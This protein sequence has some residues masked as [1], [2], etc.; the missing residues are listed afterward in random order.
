MSVYEKMVASTKK[1]VESG[2]PAEVNLGDSFNKI[3]AFE[4][5]GDSKPDFYLDIKGGKKLSIAEGKHQKPDIV[6][7][8]DKDTMTSIRQGKLT[9]IGAF[10]RGNLEVAGKHSDAELMR[11][12]KILF[13]ESK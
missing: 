4:V 1:Y 6:I 12:I 13:P 9:P 10:M 11:L 2:I 5:S 3:I 7:S 8:S